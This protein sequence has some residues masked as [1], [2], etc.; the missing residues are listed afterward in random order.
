MILIL[1]NW[2]IFVLVGIASHSKHDKTDERAD[3]T[4]EEQVQKHPPSAAACVVK[5]AHTN[6]NRR[7]EY[8]QTIDEGND[9]HNPIKTL[10]VVELGN[11][12]QDGQRNIEKEVEQEVIPILTAAGATIEIRI[13]LYQDF[14]YI[15]QADCERRGGGRYYPELSRG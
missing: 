6:G 9:C 2:T 14:S 10:N 11:I 15:V 3:T 13:V 8:S 5:T 7:D 1:R 12:A 4:T